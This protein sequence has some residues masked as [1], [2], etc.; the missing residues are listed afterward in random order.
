MTAETCGAA[1]QE[2]LDRLAEQGEDALTAGEALA[3]ELMAL[4]T[5]G[6]TAL[7]AGLPAD[8]LAGALDDPSAAGLLV[9]HD[10]HPQDVTGRV[11]RALASV[12]QLR[13]ERVD[14]DAT[15]GALTLR[16]PAQGG[17]CGCGGGGESAVEDALACHAPEVTSIVWRTA[18]ADPPLLQ[19]GS[20]PPAAVR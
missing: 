15:T 7:L 8:A 6:L 18:P 10:L 17:G 19:I 2:A 16:K 11:E 3:R 1:V 13:A 5:E 14:F 9:L 12:P 20:R 4:H